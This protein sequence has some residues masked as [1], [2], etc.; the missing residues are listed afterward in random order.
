MSTRAPRANGG[1]VTEACELPAKVSR[2]SKAGLSNTNSSTRRD[3]VAPVLLATTAKPTTSGEADTNVKALNGARF[4][5]PLSPWVVIHGT[6]RGTIAPVG[7]RLVARVRATRRSSTVGRS[8]TAAPTD[9][10]YIM[11]N[12]TRQASNEGNELDRPF[13]CVVEGVTSCARS[14]PLAGGWATASTVGEGRALEVP[15]YE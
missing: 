3:V 11:R 1:D 6:G 15:G 8:L 9:P 2:R 13:G 12:S 7:R 5:P 14:K 4:S 10:C